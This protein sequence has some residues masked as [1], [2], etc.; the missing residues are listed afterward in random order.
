[1]SVFLSLYI[2]ILYYS[3][4]LC[5]EDCYRMTR[6]LMHTLQKAITGSIAAQ[7]RVNQLYPVIPSVDNRLALCPDRTGVV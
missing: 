2:Y 1:M 7:L 5:E 4:L 3:S 6:S